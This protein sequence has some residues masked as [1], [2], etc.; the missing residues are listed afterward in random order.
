MDLHSPALA[1][2]LAKHKLV[3]HATVIAPPGLDIPENCMRVKE[4][5]AR[6]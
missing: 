2:L 5:K 3:A 4:G 1:A 6:H